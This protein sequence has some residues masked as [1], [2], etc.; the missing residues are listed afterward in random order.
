MLCHRIRGPGQGRAK[1][2]SSQ[3]TTIGRQL[4]DIVGN[5]SSNQVGLGT[6]VVVQRGLCKAAADSDIPH[7]RFTDAILSENTTSAF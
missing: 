7:A 4:R 6:K 3:I 2:S 1:V 5:E